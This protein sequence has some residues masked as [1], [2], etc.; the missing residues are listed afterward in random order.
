M[1]KEEGKCEGCKNCKCKNNKY[2]EDLN[3]QSKSNEKQDE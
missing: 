1:L 3:E 2:Y